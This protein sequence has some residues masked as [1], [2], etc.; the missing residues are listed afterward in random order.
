V[1]WKE[2][3]AGPRLA[4]FAAIMLLGNIAISAYML[5]QLA[6]LAPSDPMST[7]LSARNA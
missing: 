2:T 1:L 7:L 6:R 3:R 4:W 5:R